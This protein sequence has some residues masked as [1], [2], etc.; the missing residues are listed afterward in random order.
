MV[1]ASGASR[2]LLAVAIHTVIGVP[3]REEKEMC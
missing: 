2:A 3:R 1:R